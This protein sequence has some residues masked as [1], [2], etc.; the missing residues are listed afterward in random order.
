MPQF[1]ASTI[2]GPTQ[3]SSALLPN[4]SLVP[5]SPDS[6]LSPRALHKR[7][8]KLV[9]PKLQIQL[10]MV[11]VGLS[12]L[13]VVMQFI[14]FQSTLSKLSYQLPNDGLLLMESVNS[15]LPG[16]LGVTLLAILPLTY[17]VGVLTTFRIAGPVYRMNMYLRDVAEHG[18]HGPCRLRKGDK[19][20]ELAAQLSK[21][22]EHLSE[23][24][25]QQSRKRPDDSGE[26]EAA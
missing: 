17:L 5:V 6:P 14:L 21:T 15:A 20:Q 4:R 7:R 26:T 3:E 13:G 12:A 22:V 10:T 23:P 16:I 9:D 11:F 2:R 25:S 1:S 24:G 8:L 18:Y 19:L